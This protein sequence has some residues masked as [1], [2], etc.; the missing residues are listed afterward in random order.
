MKHW[1]VAAIVGVS[2]ACTSIAGLDNDYELDE[3]G[4]GGEGGAP[5]GAGGAGGGGTP[6]AGG[7]SPED[8]FDSVDNDN[9]GL[10]DCADASDCEPVAA[11]VPA[12]PP[13]WTQYIRAAVKPYSEVK[14]E[15]EPC[16][17]GS[18]PASYL[19]GPA[20]A[21][22]CGS[23][24]CNWTG[25]KCTAPTIECFGLSSNCTDGV[26]ATYT[27][28]NEDCISMPNFSPSS[29]EDSC[30]ISAPAKV[31]DA[32]TCV[33][34]GG[35]ISAGPAWQE[36]VDVCP[37]VVAVGAGCDD[38]HACAAKPDP[39]DKGSLCIQAAGVQSCPSGWTGVE[40]VVYEGG[41]DTRSCSSCACNDDVSC[42]NDGFYVAYD[43]NFCS[44]P[45]DM[46]SGMGCDSGV[47]TIL[48]PDGSLKPTVSSAIDGTCGGGQPMGAVTG[49]APSTICCM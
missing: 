37:A 42:A 18:L 33:A 32:G 43:T 1:G 27:A 13:G 30:R 3:D 38:S 34:S 10:V 41:K 21:P 12:V 45:S 8:C 23:C 7:S 47:G 4:E 36:E 40:L 19:K 2:A 28:P 39:D 26:D 35:E 6:G 24:F 16:S 20:G 11:C 17:D 15:P 25:A 5:Q 31:S 46:V 29:T 22:S 49:E 9:D 48:G 44:G 14:P